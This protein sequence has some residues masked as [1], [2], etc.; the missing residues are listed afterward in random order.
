MSELAGGFPA[1]L[2]MGLALVRLLPLSICHVGRC[3]FHQGTLAP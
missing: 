3:I 1:F 2:G